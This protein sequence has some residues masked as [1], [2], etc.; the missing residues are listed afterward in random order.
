MAIAEERAPAASAPRRLGSAARWRPLLGLVVPVL[1]VLFWHV[2]ATTL[3]PSNI[4][5]PP[6]GRV[7]RALADLALSGALWGHVE[8]SLTRVAGGYILAVLVGVPVGI[9]M[10]ASQTI[11]ALLG[12]SVNGLRPIP[13]AAWVPLSIIL[14]GIGE[15]PAIFLVFVGT[16]WAII[17][18]TSHG[19][20][21]V[22]KH[23][24]WAALTM[25]ATRFQIF[26]RVVFPAAL[27]SIFAGMR[28]A[29]GI[30]FT[31]VIVAELIAVRS[32]IGYMITEAR[33]IVRADLVI[34]G[35]IVIAIV[36]FL[37]DAGVRWA[38]RRALRW[39][40]GLMSDT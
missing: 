10:G 33:L 38:M 27:P 40:K 12:S 7:F 30:A 18:N 26:R 5:L 17:L 4:L 29:V 16:V 37:L 15:Q 36:G 34:A 2:A 24:I 8:A 3:V 1:F 21:N 11:E 25:G 39:Q 31:C 9:A 19:V 28:I 22:P 14:M 32:G 13:V 20:R 6:P 35:M 23:L